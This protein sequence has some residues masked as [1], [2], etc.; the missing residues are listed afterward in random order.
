M[1]DNDQVKED[2]VPCPEIGLRAVSAE[3]DQP[4]LEHVPSSLLSTS[5]L[6]EVEAEPLDPQF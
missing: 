6:I 5:A 3:D 4:F 2:G 1:L